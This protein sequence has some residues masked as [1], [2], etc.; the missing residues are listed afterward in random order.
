M[1]NRAPAKTA[2]TVS[3]FAGCGAEESSAQG[4]V[5]GSTLQVTAGT[6]PQLEK[7]PFSLVQAANFRMLARTGT[8]KQASAAV[9]SSP[10]AVAK[11]V[12]GIEKVMP[13]PYT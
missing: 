13:L 11:S 8:V 10:A 3:W 2:S 12:A 1:G 5:N 6:Q 9:G 4:R 7:L